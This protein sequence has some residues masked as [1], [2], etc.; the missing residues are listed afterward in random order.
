MFEHPIL[1]LGFNRPRQSERVFEAIRQLQPR[2][3]YIA[4]DGPRI[5]VANEDKK[6]NEVKDIVSSIEWNCQIRR[7]YRNENLGCKIAVSSAID[8]FFSQEEEG[9]ILEDDCLPFRD[10]FFFCSEMLNRYRFDSRIMQIS[11]SNIH[12]GW[13]RDSDYSYHFGFYGSI[14][15]WATWRRAW[16]LYDVDAQI[17]PEIYRK[18]KLKDVL[19][20]DF[21]ILMRYNVMDRVLSENEDTWDYQWTFA[22]IVNSGLSIT[23][24]SNLVSNIGF[25]A[26]ATRTSKSNSMAEL[27]IQELKKPL[28]HPPYVIPDRVSD[29]HLLQICSGP[30]LKRI[31]KH[32]LW[33]LKYLNRLY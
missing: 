27:T 9:I 2:K 5:G 18:K 31:A 30:F 19:I 10:F 3:L 11:G 25:D 26:S 7:L 33:K 20:K 28:K 23:P 1:F 24:N 4:L 22:K 13:N 29:R 8:W 32:L 17:Y 15:G 14:W 16:S 6:C 21:D 12:Q